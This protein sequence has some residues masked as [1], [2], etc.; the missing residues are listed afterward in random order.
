MQVVHAQ[1]R[2]VDWLATGNVTWAY[3]DICDY[4]PAASEPQ[5]ILNAGCAG[6]GQGQSCAVMLT[7]EG[8]S[9]EFFSI[10]QLNVSFWS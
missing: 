1:K 10:V 5:H 4:L 9:H 2:L 7:R 3:D 6:A 8:E